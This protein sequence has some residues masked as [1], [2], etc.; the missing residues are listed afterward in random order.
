MALVAKNSND[1]QT[2]LTFEENPS[3]TPMPEP[4]SQSLAEFSR[5]LEESGTLLSDIKDTALLQRELSLIGLP[6]YFVEPSG[7]D[8]IKV[9]RQ[10]DLIISG[11]KFDDATVLDVLFE[12]ES[13]SGIPISFDWDSR[14]VRQSDFDKKISINQKDASIETLLAAI[15]QE[16]ALK[17]SA[18]DIGVTYT[19]PDELEITNRKWPLE[20]NL[21][22]DSTQLLQRFIIERIA[23]EAQKAESDVAVAVTADAVA[24]RHR[25]D[26]HQRIS[27][28]LAEMTSAAKA[29]DATPDGR[30]LVLNGQ[31]VL[32]KPLQLLSS[33]PFRKPYQLNSLLRRIREATGL[34]IFV[35]WKRLG[36]L[37]WTPYTQFPGDFN[38]R[39]AGSAL[40]QVAKSLKATWIVIDEDK[41]LLTTFEQAAKEGD[42]EV[43]PVKHLLSDRLSSGQLKR[44][45]E[46]TLTKQL[47][48]PEV[49]VIYFPEC[50]CLVAR[51]PQSLHRQMY[52]ILERLAKDL[53][54]KDS[55]K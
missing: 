2:P 29:S 1:D 43:Y 47:T 50:E 40:E 18:D 48:M 9:G 51:A 54:T 55:G 49:A 25:A 33:N 46:S 37:G 44:V 39:T 41:V 17:V 52:S 32:A 12:L 3:E 23:P 14:A 22:E 6:N 30:P 19:A 13:L 35:D 34:K 7:K 26:V 21:N 11:L 20:L 31:S 27:R 16:L 5:A 36:P 38:E 4:K 28:L 8:P 42:I 15:A 53:G 10:L 45:L 24:V